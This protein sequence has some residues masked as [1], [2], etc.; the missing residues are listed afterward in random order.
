MVGVSYGDSLMVDW[1]ICGFER[2]FYSVGCGS[3]VRALRI[4]LLKREVK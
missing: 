1:C 4:Y 2:G 3:G